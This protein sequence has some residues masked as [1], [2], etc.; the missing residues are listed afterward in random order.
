MLVTNK[1]DTP[2][3][4]QQDVTIDMPMKPFGTS[5]LS[6]YIH[7][8]VKLYYKA[9]VGADTNVDCNHP[10]SSLPIHPST[11]CYVAADINVAA[12][13]YDNASD[14]HGSFEAASMVGPYILESPDTL[15]LPVRFLKLHSCQGYADIRNKPTRIFTIAPLTKVQFTKGLIS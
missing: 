7:P 1:V 11:K 6:L 12:A 3:H 10:S 4:I 15:T 14:S 9:N 13:N 5:K 8:L 2:E